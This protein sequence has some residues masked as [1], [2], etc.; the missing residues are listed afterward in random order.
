MRSPNV[1]FARTV[2]KPKVDAIAVLR[3][4]GDPLRVKPCGPAIGIVLKSLSAEKRGAVRRILV[5]G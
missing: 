5:A 2:R 4:R 3:R 1:C